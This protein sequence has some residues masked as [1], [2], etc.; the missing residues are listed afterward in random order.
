VGEL[1]WVEGTNWQREAEGVLDL[2]AVEWPDHGL[3]AEGL[4]ARLILEGGSGALKGE[5]TVDKVLFG[6]YVLEKVVVEVEAPPDGPASL[7]LVQAHL[8][9]GRVWTAPFFWDW[10]AGTGTIPL[11]FE[12]LDLAGL[13]EHI[14]SLRGV[15]EGRL[16]G[17]L[18]LARDGKRWRARHGLLE[19]SP[20]FPARLE[21]PANGLLTA[22]V[23]PDSARYQ[24]LLVV[25]E[26]L[27]HLALEVLRLELYN[28]KTPDTALSVRLEGVSTSPKAVVPVI[29]NLHVNGEV[30]QLLR[31]M[32][33]EEF[34]FEF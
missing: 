26:G 23:D 2:S 6:T 28:P 31:L 13:A 19:L 7:Q 27:K 16:S 29:L 10:R 22:G 11:V 9:G 30:D 25:E 18:P 32:E 12:E 20:G 17:H 15:I 21:Y 3:R 8:L 34:E 24:Q 1:R 14:P 5:I 4:E 33:S